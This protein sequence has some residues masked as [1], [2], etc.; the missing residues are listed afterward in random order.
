MLF[1]VTST[2]YKLH[3]AANEI[4]RGISVPAFCVHTYFA[5]GGVY[6][7]GVSFA[8]LSGCGLIPPATV[9]VAAPPSF[10]SIPSWS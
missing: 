9:L 10:R 3:G 5:P 1:G 2:Y 7:S 4:P 6:I 8:V